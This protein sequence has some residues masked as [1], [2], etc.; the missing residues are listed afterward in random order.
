MTKQEIRAE[1]YFKIN[2]IDWHFF[3]W[4]FRQYH[5]SHNNEHPLAK[6]IIDCCY[7]CE[8]KM[9]G[10]ASNFIDTLCSISGRE[11]FNPHYDQL[12]QLLAELLVVAHLAN[13]FDDTWIFE[14][15]PTI[16]ESNKN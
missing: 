7:L 4:H 5:P 16:G 3:H 1:L 2:S 12:L 13:V 8:Q 11:Y 6:S 15:E 9:P 14:E 10:Y